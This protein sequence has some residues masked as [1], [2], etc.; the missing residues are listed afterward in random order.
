MRSKGTNDGGSF[1]PSDYVRGK[2]QARASMFAILLFVLVLAG[3]IGAFFVNHQ[4]WSRVREE[5]KMVAASFKEETAK[6]EQLKV[7]EQQRIVLTDKAEIV[8]ALKD[9]VPRSVLVGELIRG[10]G[11][12]I[13]LTEIEL[14]GDRV[15]PPKPV[16]DPKKKKVKSIGVNGVGSGKDA[17]TTTPKV[18]PPK[19]KF[20]LSVNGLSENNDDIA[21]YLSSLKSSPLLSDVELQ[22]INQTLID[23]VEYRKFK[24]TMNL[25]PSADAANVEGTVAIDMDG[26][27]VDSSK[28]ILTHDSTNESDDAVDNATDKKLAGVSEDT[29]D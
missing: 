19:F 27:I 9:R 2:G 26:N 28:D 5:Q 4:R 12:G 7:L 1:L 23:S 18:H 11:S 14:E 6:I 13:T 24:I 16:A 17:A 15:R 25:S 8:T 21:D 29:Q 22:Y 10:I 3:V 20:I